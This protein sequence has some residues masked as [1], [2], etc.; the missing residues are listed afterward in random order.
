M[1]ERPFVVGDWINV[2]D[3]VGV[4][5]SIDLLA[6]RIRLFDNSLVRIP[7][8]NIIKNR[9]TNLTHF[10]IRRADITLGV[11]YKE[12]VNRVKDLLFALAD[13]NPLVLDNPKPQF[14]YDGYGNSALELRFCVWTTKENFVDVRNALRYEIKEV[15][16]REGIEI[17]FPHRTLYTG[18]VTDPFPVRVVSSSPDPSATENAV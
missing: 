17:P 10:P 6:V 5:V 7:N 16:D 15:F 2:D 12:D 1:A 14:F 13:R 3:V 8:E 9:V 18:A 4:V 11:A